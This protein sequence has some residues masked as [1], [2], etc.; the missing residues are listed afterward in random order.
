VDAA[1]K[2]L[3]VNRGVNAQ[4]A[5]GQANPYTRYTDAAELP[6]PHHYRSGRVPPHNTTDTLIGP[7][8]R[9]PPSLQLRP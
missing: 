9:R 1:D 8:S 7:A 4:P 3:W 6:R 2:P 5:S